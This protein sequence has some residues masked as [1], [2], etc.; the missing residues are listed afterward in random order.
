MKLE[1]ITLE[2]FRCYQ[3]LDID[4][5]S[6][7]TVLTAN[8]GQGKTSILDAIRI[9]LWPFISQFDLAK[10]AYADPANT[11]IIDDVKISKSAEQR[12]PIFGALD[13]MARQFPSS[14][15]AV[16]CYKTG[17]SSWQRYRDSEA[18]KSQT[19]DDVGA[20]ALKDSASE[21]QSTI[22][23]LSLPPRTLPVFGYY[24]T[25]RL[26]REKRLMDGKKGAKERNNEQIRTFAYRDCLDPAS[27]FKQFQDWFTSAYLKVMEYQIKQL[28]DGA[29]F[30]E[31]PNE[32]RRPVKVVQDAVNEVLKPVGWQNLQYSEKYDKSL[33]LKHPNHGVM[34]ISQLSDGIKNMLAMIADI[35]YRCVLLNGHLQDQAAKQSPGVV[36]ID[37]V[38]MHLHP[39]WQQTV[40]ASLR[41]A[42][43]NIQFIVTT[44]SPQVLSTVPAESIRVIK[45][46]VD[47]NTDEIIS[48]A[49]PPTK[50][51]RGV[52][53]ADVMAELQLVDPIPDVEEAYWLTQYKQLVTQ[54]GHENVQGNLLK[55]K[56]IEHFGES[57]QEWLEC[58]RLIRLQA[59]K[60]KLPKRN[61]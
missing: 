58:E 51:S 23:N 54:H 6:N 20:K 50:Q 14:I 55:E 30:I 9:A 44:H 36:M 53:S 40:I 22:R 12:S 49:N 61:N 17:I 43:P 33:V 1:K 5:H 11:I 25:G 60:A 56:I 2:N 10:T 35:A 3:H 8:N 31:V 52:A 13:E 24:G 4:L 16:G 39:Q 42:F 47:I 15:T 59:M 28:E 26:W 7:I 48:T 37:E 45:H 18:K 41:Q 19:K 27:S 29:T 57:H 21:L 32:L 38:D 46:E 34:K